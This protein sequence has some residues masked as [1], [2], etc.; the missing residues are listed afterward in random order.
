MVHRT[1]LF[2]AIGGMLLADRVWSSEPPVNL[3]PR[4]ASKP[5]VVMVP[6]AASTPSKLFRS[7]YRIKDPSFVLAQVCADLNNDGK[8]EIVYSSRGTKA[9]HLLRAADGTPLWSR[10]FKGDHQ[11]VM[12]YDLDRDGND[13]ILFTVSSPGRLYVLDPKTG[14]VLRQWGAGDWKIGNSP[15]IVDADRDGVLDGYFGTRGRKLVRLNMADLTPITERTP[16]NQCGCHT[17]VMDVDGDGRWDLFAGSGDDHRLKGVLY[18]Y[19]PLTLKRI[20]SY[21]TNDNAASADPV[22]AD[23]D[24]DG[25]VEIIKSV[26]NYAGDDAHDAIYAFETDGTLLWKV[27]RFSG[28]D[29]PNVADLDGDGQVEI[30]GMTFGSEV[31]CLDSKGHVRWRKD[32]RPELDDSAHAYMAPVLCDLNSD[33]ELEILALTNGKGKANGILFA[34]DARGNV[35]DRFDVGGPRYWGTAFVCNV[36]DDPYLE[37]V[38]SGS[39]GL[40]VIETKG[41][42]PNTEHFQRRRTYQRLN[43]VPWAYEDTYFIHRG[44]KEGVAN[45]TDNLVLKKSGERYIASGT[46]TTELLTLPPRCHFDTLRFEALEPAGTELRVSIVDGSGKPI[47]DNVSNGQRLHIG[48]PIRL[49]FSFSTTDRSKTPLLDSYRLSF[50]AVR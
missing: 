17:S 26:D 32:L 47:T 12:A 11:S 43:V 45:L 7:Q 49:R 15:V 10:K 42:G 27:E 13:E 8:R 22:L 6:T 35:L 38:A 30:I 14:D 33:R 50:D 37:L 16:W 31:Y 41:F 20:W 2:F 23:I 44:Q 24:G 46:F 28:E 25:Q 5:I 18:R 29:S 40:D 34:L 21:A 36:D 1:I 9:T 48:R 39:G 19:D 4:G 3:F